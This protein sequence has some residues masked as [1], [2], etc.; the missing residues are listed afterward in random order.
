MGA[1]WCSV[2][3]SRGSAVV[4]THR[5]THGEDDKVDVPAVMYAD[6]G[7]ILNDYKN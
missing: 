5:R 1:D 3:A 7:E 2:S 6:W 4:F